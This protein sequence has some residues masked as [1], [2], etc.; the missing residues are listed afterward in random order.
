RHGASHP[1]RREDPRPR[2]PRQA[3]RAGQRA[4]RSDRAARARRAPHPCAGPRHEDRSVTLVCTGCRRRF[5]LIVD[6]PYTR[7][8]AA[9]LSQCP[10]CGGVVER[11]ST[12]ITAAST[13]TPTVMTTTGSPT[14]NLLFV[15]PVPDFRG[16]FNPPTP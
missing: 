12:L 6:T 1:L 4:G 9:F 3:L 10:H 5:D 13:T 16:L 14:T 8:L 7:T 11:L 15:G 2:A